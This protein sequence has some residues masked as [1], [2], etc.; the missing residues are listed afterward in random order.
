[1]NDDKQIAVYDNTVSARE[2]LSYI[3]E[4]AGGFACIGRD[5]KLYIRTIG[6]NIIDFNVEYFQNFTWGE[7]FKPSRIAYE[8]GIQDFKVG[9]EIDNTIWISQ[10][11]MYIVDLEQINNIYNHYSDFECFSFEGSTI[12]DPA[13]DMGDILVID[14]KKVIYQGSMKYLGKFKVDIFSKI[15]AKSKEQTMTTNSTSNKIRRVQS[16]ID[17]VKGEIETLVEEVGE[18]SEKVSQVIQTVDGITEKVSQN[19]TNIENVKSDAVKEALKST[20]DFLGV[21]LEDYPSKLEVETLVE[22]KAGEIETSLNGTIETQMGSYVK[23]VDMQN[24]VLQSIGSFEQTI[25]ESYATKDALSDVETQ[26]EENSASIKQTAKSISLD[27]SNK[28]TSAGITISLKDEEGNEISTQTGTINMSGVVTFSDLST[29]GSTKISGDNITTGKISADRLDLGDCVLAPDGDVKQSL[30]FSGGLRVNSNGTANGIEIYG[31]TPYIDFHYGNSSSDYTHRIIAVK[32][33]NADTLGDEML[34]CA[35]GGLLL[36]KQYTNTV[37]EAFAHIFQTN[38]STGGVTL[39]I[40]GSDGLRIVDRRNSYGQ[41][42]PVYASNLY[43]Y[44]G[45]NTS[46]NMT[47]IYTSGTQTVIGCPSGG[48]CIRGATS[49]DTGLPIQASSFNVF[50]SR[51]YKENIE[52]MTEEEADKILDVNIVTFD[53]KDK[54]TGTACRGV[55]AEDVYE[56]IP[57]VV[58][59]IEKDGKNVPDGVSYGGFVPYLIK[60]IQMM[61]KELDKLKEVRNG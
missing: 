53:Y 52:D 61:Q 37:V 11:N 31:S 36:A 30:S 40:A 10:D 39:R 21:K 51:R 1:L 48:A 57:S 13:Y 43:A 49:V 58:S 60:K 14:G 55:I 9:D 56:I 54:M 25:S 29:S 4:Q 5:G 44:N 59:L 38:S 42:L 33:Y 19:T 34:I 26:V 41:Y 27:V 16:S 3:S 22:T 17:Q 24:H 15:Q 12:V 45:T 7:R 8:D 47:N 2:Y 28:E 6:E 32:N 46:S 20:E 18:N 23:T 35:E 50:S